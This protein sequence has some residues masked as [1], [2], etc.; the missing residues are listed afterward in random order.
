MS[1]E[2]VEG[3]KIRCDKDGKFTLMSNTTDIDGVEALAGQKVVLNGKTKI[4]MDAKEGEIFECTKIKWRDKGKNFYAS[5]KMTRIE[6]ATKEK[7]PTIFDVLSMA[8]KPKG[9]IVS[10][11]VWTLLL[12]NILKGKHTVLIGPTGSGKTELVKYAA[13]TVEYAFS[14]YNLGNAID[15][16]SKLIGSM[17]LV[18]DKEGQCNVT[19]FEQARFVK[20]IQT[21]KQVVLLDEI[22]RSN[23]EVN[24]ILLT[25][26]DGQGYIEL[27][28]HPELPIIYKDPKCV[29]IGTANIGDEYVGTSILDRAFKD[30]VFMIEMDYLSAAEEKAL[31]IERTKIDSENA[32]LIAE[33]AE[34]CRAMWKNNE[35]GTPV[36]T[37]M[38][39]EAGY[40]IEDGFSFD[41]S[42]EAAILPYFDD[43]GTASSDAT[44]IK[45]AMQKKG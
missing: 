20:D 42:I 44:K 38:T 33:F 5:G 22:N 23:P 11:S 12:R 13:E 21:S 6:A 24:N 19:H 18:M 31:L 3:I 8:P 15:P 17:N 9:F 45:Q 16:R 39:L 28:E 40:L 10:D 32:T 7:K 37:R 36:S 2:K 34:T 26:L 1:K 14:A 41:K 35:L 4:K 27:D 43:D 25:L 29:L 30:R